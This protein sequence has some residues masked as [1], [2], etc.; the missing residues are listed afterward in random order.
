MLDV[1]LGENPLTLIEN[2]SVKKAFK[3]L[4]NEAESHQLIS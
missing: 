4:M 2:L 1:E 3:D